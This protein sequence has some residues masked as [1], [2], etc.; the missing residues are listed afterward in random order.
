MSDDLKE[1]DDKLEAHASRVKEIGEE[2]KA[3]LESESTEAKG[4][5][6]DL[7]KEQKR[8]TE[9][10]AP[11]LADKERAEQKAAIEQTQRQLESLMANT[12]T[13]SKA[14]A[15]GA[16][17][18]ADPAVKAGAFIGAIAGMNNRDPEVYAASKA[19]LDSLSEYEE[20]WGKATLGTTDAT[21]GWIVPNALVDDLIKPQAYRNVYG[22]LVTNINGV[23][24]AAVDI[25]W[26]SAA[27]NRAVIAPFGST[28]ENVDLVYNG[29]T[30]TMYTLARIHDVS[31]QFL[32][33]SQ[34]AA[35]QDIMTELASAFA[36]GE[37]FYIREGTGSSQ[38]YGL[39]TALNA[40]PAAFTTAHTAAA[41]VAGS[42]I[43]AI[44][45]A[46][47]DLS[48]RNVIPTA[49]VM[50]SA[51]VWAMAVAGGTGADSGFFLNGV[52]G[53]TQFPNLAAGTVISPFGIP[54]IGDPEFGTDDLVVG[55]FKSLK[56]YH[57]LSYRVDS[58]SVA[59]T[60]W[61]ANLTGFRGEMELGLDARAAVFAGNFQLVADIVT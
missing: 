36:R 2:I 27:P 55:D 25:P 42:V 44:A 58:S 17:R 34:G 4:R 15:I 40:A 10:V 53:V 23:T 41:T 43:A 46:A 31:N 48:T 54:V 24:A 47:G 37:N 18:S 26:R 50:S 16:G 61:D 51:N 60:R 33:Q 39:V 8:I 32:R 57:G 38:P 59:G 1:L 6:D 49:A 30:A 5:L 20:S 56:V 7:T 3:N 35:E 13:A 9:E 11:L 52:G 14:E 12:R 28:K 22:P 21:G 29:Y 45:K 19:T